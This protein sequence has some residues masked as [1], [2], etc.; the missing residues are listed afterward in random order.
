MSYICLMVYICIYIYIYISPPPRLGAD[1]V[2]RLSSWR[3]TSFFFYFFFLP[4]SSTSLPSYLLR[5]LTSSPGRPPA[6]ASSEL[7]RPLD[8][9]WTSKMPP[10]R[11]QDA[12]CL[13]SFFGCFLHR[14]SIDFWCQLGSNLPPKINENPW[15]IDAKSIHFFI[16]FWSIFV[17]CFA[18][19]NLKIY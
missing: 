10:R 7:S 19:W 3:V 13:P 2:L 12:S 6:V 5:D 18:P 1:G 17:R 16:V 15:K 14:F 4:T 11:L 8:T 9:S